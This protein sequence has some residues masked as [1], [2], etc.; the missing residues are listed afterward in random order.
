MTIVVISPCQLYFNLFL[1]FQQVILLVLKYHWIERGPFKCRYFMFVWIFCFG[2]PKWFNNSNWRRYLKKKIKT[3]WRCTKKGQVAKMNGV[4]IWFYA[5]VLMALV[6]V[7]F[8]YILEIYHLISYFLSAGM[9]YE[10]FKCT[11]VNV[12]GKNLFVLLNSTHIRCGA[13]NQ[14]IFFFYRNQAQ[15]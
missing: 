1:S 13:F 15:Q 4:F 9:E 12:T 6:A 14:I 5:V 3:H 11:A 10:I 2:F 8:K 7:A